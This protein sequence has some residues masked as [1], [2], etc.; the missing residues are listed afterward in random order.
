MAMFH[1]KRSQP[2]PGSTHGSD[3]GKPEHEK[4][5]HFFR[6][7]A[8]SF[9][10]QVVSLPANPSILI[11]LMGAL[12]DVTRGMCLISQIKDRFP[13]SSLTWLVEPKWGEIVK[14]HPRIDNVLIFDRPNWRQ[15]I[16]DIYRQLSSIHFDCVFDLQRHFKSGLFSFFSRAH[17]RIGFHPRD[18]KEGNWLFNNRHLQK[19]DDNLPKILHY[20][21]FTK[22]VGIAPS[23]DL[24]FGLSH[25]QLSNLNPE[26]S[27]VL[28]PRY[29]VVILGSTWETKEWSVDKYQ[30]LI[31][32]LL[33]ETDMQVVLVDA[34]GKYDLA[35]SLEG[36]ICN[37]RLV[38]L[39]G[40]TSVV[41][42]AA[43]LARAQG[44]VGPDCGA[45]HIAS[46]VH[47]PYVSLFGPTSHRRT[48]P[49]QSEHL[50]V[51]AGIECAPCYKKKC[52]GKNK[53]CMRAIRVPQVM[54]KIFQ[55]I[56][57]TSER[58]VE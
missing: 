52:P 3:Q 53:E 5:S 43:V 41:E 22:S 39:V 51:T 47:T 12:G 7:S 4:T 49:F 42:L 16:K 20:L 2:S 19:Q 36:K 58:H 17:N 37:P 23:G 25:L 9:Q 1:N 6:P 13:N 11:I 55:V 26:L 18:A 56:G 27:S 34:K 30:D 14:Q 57:D 35:R 38:N 40:R 15:G 24:D 8:Q 33:A 31:H 29:W 10:P 21:Q 44:A 50:V 28:D 45:G 46:A 54:H 32:K 48:A